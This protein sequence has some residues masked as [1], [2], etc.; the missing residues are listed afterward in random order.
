MMDYAL[1]DVIV[2]GPTLPKTQVV[3]GVTTV[4]PIISFEDKAQRRLEVKAGSTLM[5]GI[6]NEHQL[7]FNSIK[8]A[9]QLM[10]AIEKRFG[11]NT[12]QAVNTANGVSTAGTQVNDDNSTNI[13]NLSDAVICTFLASQSNSSQLE[14][15]SILIGMRLLPLI[16]PRWNVTISIRGAT[17]KCR[18][19]RAQDNRYRESTRRNVPVET[20]NSSALVSYDRLGG[21]DWSDQVEDGPNY[22]L[23]A[24]FTLGYKAGLKSVKERLEFF[25]TNKS[26]YLEDIKKLKFEI[27]CNEITI[28]ELRR[29]LETAQREKDCIQLTVEKLKN[30]SKSLN[31][32]INSQIVDNCKKGLGY[33][34][35]PPP[36]TSL[37]MPPKPHLFYIGLEEFTS[38]PAVEILMLKLVNKFLRVP[39]KNNMYSVDLKI[40]IP[41]GG[42]TCLFAKAT[43]DE[44]RLWHRRLG[45]LNFKTMN[46]LVKGNLS[47]IKKMY[48]L[49]VID[50]YSRFTWVFFLSTKDETSGILKSFITRIENLVDHKVKVI[51][52]DNGTE[53]KNKDMN[54]FCEMKGIMRQY[55]VARTPQ[56]NGLAKKRN[57]TIIEAARTMLAD[58]KLPTTFWAEALNTACYV[59]PVTI[60]NTI[61][62]LGKFD[63]KANEGFFVGYSLNSKACRVFNSRTR[64]VEETLHIRF[65]ENTPDNVDN[66]LNWLFDI[67]ALT[68]IMNYQPVVVNEVPRQENECKDQEEKD[69]VNNTNRVNAVSLTINAANNEVNVVGRKLSIGLPDDLNMHELEDISIFKDSNEDLFGAEA[70]LNNM[71]S[72]FQVS[73]IPTTRIHQDH[74]LEQVIGKMHL[75]PQTRRMP[76]N[77][78]ELGV[79]WTTAKSKTVNREVQIH[80]LVDGMKVIITESSVRRDLQLADENE[81]RIKKLKKKHMSRTHKLKRLYKVGLTVRVISFSD[82]KALDK[83]D[84][85]KQERIYEIDADKDI[86]LVSIHDDVQDEG[87]EDVGEEEVVEVVTTT[88][89][90]INAVGDA[91]HVTTAIDDIPVSIAETIVTTALT[92]TAES[93]KK[94]VEVTQD[95]KR[96]RVIIQEPEE[97]TTTN[98]ASLQQ[99][100]VQNK[101]KWKTKLIE[102][103]K[104]PKKIKHQIRADEE[105]AKKLQAEMQAQ[106]D[107]EDR[108]ARERSRQKEE[109]NI[110]LTETWK[111]IQAKVDTDYQLAE[112]LQAEEQQ[113]LN[114]E[115]KA[116]LFT[117][118]LMKRRKFF[119]AKRNEENRHRPP[120]KA[121]Q[122]SLMCTYLKNMDG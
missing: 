109:A 97:K 40:I 29:K 13:D 77:L 96:K 54:Q 3:E 25:K 30:A 102:E 56:Q 79:F 6:L 84:I 86:V 80:A 48:C 58:L 71:E 49:V 87:I 75:A 10:E 44:S 95:P 118:L 26:I 91:A 89:M 62:H 46:K 55:S 108:K 35:V 2:N 34:A 94:N 85:S 18:A 45:H 111:D 20:T 50:D 9:K 72:V 5:M 64:I 122:R 27:Y 82:D 68:K 115:E 53:F 74:S 78:E 65:S 90:I 41:K 23:M 33:N 28:R 14:G 116:K 32:I 66:G 42:L 113:E 43:S 106:I 24:Y 57:K 100:Q 104:M 83:Q 59:C 114:E 47:L 8:D 88:T 36:Y 76:K 52:C 98:T 1:W 37:F 67:G 51:R 103:P 119:A 7:K 4:M 117:K 105:L 92:I 21:Y 112:R 17:R 81:R 16:K 110:A 93:T 22:A 19:P 101:G 99:L 12:A 121:Q 11:V 61:D 15:S 60:L 63:G 107:E 73:P 69:N 70:D 38:E 120:T 39:R 31:K